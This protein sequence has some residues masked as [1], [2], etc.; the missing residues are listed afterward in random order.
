MIYKHINTT[1]KKL[2]A[3]YGLNEYNSQARMYYATI[4]RTTTMDPLA[5]NYYHISPYA[6]CGNNPI[7]FV[8]PD[9]RI[10]RIKDE[11]DSAIDALY[12]TL[13]VTDQ[14]YVCVDEQGLVV[15]DQEHVKN[16]ESNNYK[17]LAELA[18]SVIEYTI[19]TGNCI[20]YKDENG[21]ILTAEMFPVYY[22]LDDTPDY[23][24]FDT[25]ENG[26]R[27]VTQTPGDTPNKRNSVDNSVHITL[28]S[29]LS[30]EGKAQT[31]SHELFGH[32]LLYDRGLPYMH[33]VHNVGGIL[34]DQNI[35]L[36]IAIITAIAETKQNMR[37]K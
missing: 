37:G 24:G 20:Q 33:D 29:T 19:A 14:E 36:R 3:K 22:E 10:V 13:N 2:I 26:W 31:L 7:A 27:G 8:D 23:T 1:P 34:I 35:L 17:A 4:M 5:E 25:H 12:N 32:A 21:K 28:N 18:R 15:V 6:W 30:V 16:T 9:G 11:D